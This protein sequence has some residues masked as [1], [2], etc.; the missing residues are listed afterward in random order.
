MILRFKY[1]TARS[2]RSI[3][4]NFSTHWLGV[5]STYHTTLQATPGQLVFNRDIL[6]DLDF[7]TDWYNIYSHK[8]KSI[9]YSNQRGN[10]KRFDYEY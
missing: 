7:H 3:W 1:L 10:A 6:F 5:R 8:Q 4:R 9:N 2:K